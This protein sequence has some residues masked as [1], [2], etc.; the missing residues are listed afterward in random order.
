MKMASF[1]LYL[2]SDIDPAF[3]S[4]MINFFKVSL[5]LLINTG[6]VILAILS[7]ISIRFLLL[8]S[9]ELYLHISNKLLRQNLESELEFEDWP[10]L[11]ELPGVPGPPA[12]I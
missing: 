1:N 12:Y 7:L 8:F 10:E 5:H 6:V 9:L 11:D 4:S 3:F 2:E